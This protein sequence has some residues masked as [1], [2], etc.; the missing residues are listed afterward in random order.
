[1]KSKIRS[2]VVLYPSRLGKRYARYTLSVVKETKNDIKK[3]LVSF[4]NT[5]RDDYIDDLAVLLGDVRDALVLGEDLIILN[6]IRNGKAIL[7]FTRQ[8]V[9]SSLK[10]LLTV[11]PS[12]NLGVDIFVNN[13]LVKNELLKS[14]VST[15]T[16][17]IT[18]INENLLN[19]VA[20]IVESSFRAG[21]STNYL[22]EQL[23][24]RFG[25]SDNKARLIARSQTASVHSDYIR[26]EHLTL[27]IGEYVWLTSNDER[28]RTSHKVL[29]NKICSWNDATIYRDQNSNIWKKKSSIGGDE[30]Q[31]G[32]AP[33]CRCGLKAVIQT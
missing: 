10:G 7:D 5:R 12:P 9:I 21:N 22:Q 3:A 18:S 27:G 23:K 1:M 15:N 17:L 20:V 19:D 26:Q 8:Q 16:N 28:T 32:K 29:N 2:G 31:V 14:W 6:V 30:Q 4:F 24:T 25:V 13:P 11:S 33:N